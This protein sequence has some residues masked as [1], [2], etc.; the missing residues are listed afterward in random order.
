M[1]APHG[2]IT[3]VELPQILET[4]GF[5]QKFAS[6]ISLMIGGH[7]GVFP[8]SQKLNDLKLESYIGKPVWATARTKLAETLAEL[9]NIKPFPKNENAKLDNGTIMIL[10]GLVS[11]ADWIG[12]DTQFFECAIKDFNKDFELDLDKYLEH[13]EIQAETALKQLGWLDWAEN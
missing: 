4:T 9:F 8:T 5:N 2:Y 10:A 11:V 12:S 13:S 1:D 6:Q 3:A 7:H